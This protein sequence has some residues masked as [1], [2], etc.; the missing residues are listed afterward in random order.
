[1]YALRS[2]H[3]VLSSVVV[4]LDSHSRQHIAHGGFWCD[5]SGREPAPFTQILHRQVGV[6]WWPREAALLAPAREYTRALEDKG[7]FT[8][9]IWPDHCILGSHGH[10]VGSLAGWLGGCRLGRSNPV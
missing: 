9:I 6:T 4:T 3:D 1:M 8:L 5:S 7:R 2:N 10:A